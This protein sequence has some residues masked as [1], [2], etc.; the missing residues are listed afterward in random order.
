M[1]DFPDPAESFLKSFFMARNGIAN[2]QLARQQ[3]QLAQNKFQ[4]EQSSHAQDMAQRADQ[5]KQEMDFRKAQATAETARSTAAQEEAKSAREDASQARFEGKGGQYLPAVTGDKPLDYTTGGNQPANPSSMLPQ[6]PGL[7]VPPQPVGPSADSMTPEAHLQNITQGLPMAPSPQIPMQG[8]LSPEAQRPDPAMMARVQNPM[9]VPTSQESYMPT[10]LGSATAKK[11]AEQENWTTF[12]PA[13]GKLMADSGLEA[14]WAPGDKINP[15]DEDF[16]WKVQ[17]AKATR[18][19]AIA[20]GQDAL[21]ETK[22]WHDAQMVFKEQTL[23]N[24]AKAGADPDDVEA[25]GDS[26]VQTGDATKAVGK[27]IGPVASYL[28]KRY[29]LP[30][31]KKI[32]TSLADREDAAGIMKKYIGS[33]RETMSDPEI[34]KVVN[35]YYGRLN[36]LQQAVGKN[37]YFQNDPVRTAKLQ[38][39]MTQLNNMAAVE[40]RTQIG[41]RASNQ[42]FE[43]FK[44]TNPNVKMDTPMFMGALHGVEN[45]ANNALIEAQEQRWGKG[46]ASKIPGFM[47]GLG[48]KETPIDTPAPQWVNAKDK[49]NYIPFGSIKPMPDPD[50][51]GQKVKIYHS[52]DDGKF[53]KVD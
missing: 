35:P 52:S 31:P 38:S 43:A 22:R 48:A 4:W 36:E 45:G 11:Q 13:I 44:A 1:A 6:V 10:A 49:A 26:V 8:S 53:Y 23:A 5:F 14:P 25:L 15:K 7:T 34:A 30:L 32:D 27:M 16:F 50:H 47:E 17:N 24:K 51:P 33:V 29:G 40:V 39:L 42:M 46:N 19:A 37:V 9:G 2:L 3:H 18:D 41:G 20:K 12:T 28:Q 21:E